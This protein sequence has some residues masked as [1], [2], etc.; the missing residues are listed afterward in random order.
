MNK[1][2]SSVAMILIW[3]IPMQV[4]AQKIFKVK[5][6]S[7]AGWRNPEKMHLLR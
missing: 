6:E 1:V 3:M 2:I 7:Q 4:H 5:Y